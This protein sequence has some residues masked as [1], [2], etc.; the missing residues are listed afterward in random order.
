MS[1][2]RFVK[3]QEGSYEIAL[4]EI[5]HGRKR[6]HWMW[7]IFPQIKG[8][9]YSSTAQYYAIQDKKEAENYLK[10]PVLSKRLME[11]SEELL[12]LD[13]NNASEVFGYPDDMK[14]KSSMTLFHCVSGNK[15]FQRVLEKFFDGVLDEKTVVILEELGGVHYDD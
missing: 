6:S 4:N 2:E 12:R 3:A 11:I 13:S 7:Y 14:L 9:G 10:H 15:L 1:L 5:K 8:L